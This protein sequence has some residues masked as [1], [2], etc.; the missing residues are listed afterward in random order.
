MKG[1]QK[2]NLERVRH[3]QHFIILQKRTEY[4][5]ITKNSYFNFS[6][7]KIKERTRNVTTFFFRASISDGTRK[8]K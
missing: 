7:Y 5:V 8:K 3:Q 4:R 1:Q 2:K 6:S